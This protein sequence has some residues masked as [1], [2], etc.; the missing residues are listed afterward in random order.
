MGGEINAGAVWLLKQQQGLPVGQR[1]HVQPSQC[2][3]MQKTGVAGEGGQ[4]GRAHAGV[5]DVPQYQNGQAL[6]QIPL[7]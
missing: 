4:G 2:L 7:R 6:D 3:A 1:G 5:Q